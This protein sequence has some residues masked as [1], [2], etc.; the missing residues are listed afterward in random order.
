MTN[1]V[2]SAI[3]LYTQLRKLGH[4]ESDHCSGQQENRVS[5]PGTFKA[6]L[7]LHFQEGHNV[8]ASGHPGAVGRDAW[9]LGLS[10]GG[11]TGH[12]KS[13]K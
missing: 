13:E 10:E 8:S 12:K 6:G 3:V 2:E 11:E 5:R 7:P 9:F 1:V 4:A